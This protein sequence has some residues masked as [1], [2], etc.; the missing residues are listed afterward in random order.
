MASFSS[1][2]YV[3]VFYILNFLMVGA[4]IAMY[5]RNAALDRLAAQ[6]TDADV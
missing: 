3:L 1:K 2:W 6:D 5:V 4:D